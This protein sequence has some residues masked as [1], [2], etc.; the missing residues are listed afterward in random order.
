MRLKRFFKIQNYFN[1][2]KNI[3][4]KKHKTSYSQCGEDIIIDFIFSALIKKQKPTYLD[5]GAHHPYKMSNSYLF[6]KNGSNGVCVEPDPVL[7]NYF[8]NYRKRDKCLN[9]G[10]NISNENEANFYILK[11]AKAL[12]TFSKLEAE[13]SGK[14]IEKV[15]KI[16]LL[17]INE[18][19]EKYFITAPDFISIDIEG[20]DFDV[21][22]TLNFEN[23]RPK[24]ICI[25]TLEYSTQ[26]KNIDI[27]KFLESKN[28]LAYAD[29]YINTI[30]LDK[31]YKKVTKNEKNN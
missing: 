12:N 4:G 29:T 5:L 13:K 26:I 16:P 9:L 8:K 27:I 14:E 18:I 19:I 28:Y 21:V 20:L 22:K 7:F 11:N 10:V 23:N 1:F 25:E 15:I 2:A 6:Y 30:F 17:N 24:V 3:L 31:K